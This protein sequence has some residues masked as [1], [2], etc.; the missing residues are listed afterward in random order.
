MVQKSF[1]TQMLL[2]WHIQDNNRHLPWKNEVNPYFIWLSEIMLQQTRAEQVIPYYNKFVKTY[3]TICDLAKAHEDEVFKLWQGLGYY[4]R[5]QNIIYSAR[6]VCNILHGIFP[7]TYKDILLLKG[8][9]AYTA[10]AIASFAFKLPFAVVDGNVY[11]ILSRYFGITEPIT[12]NIVQRQISNLAQELLALK[13]PDQYNQAIMDFGAV[14]CKPKEPQCCN[15]ILQPKCYAF[16]HQL[17][18]ILPIKKNKIKI[19]KRYFNFLIFKYKDQI[20]VEKRKQN[21]IWKNLYQFYLIESTTLLTLKSLSNQGIISTNSKIISSIKPLVTNQQKLTHQKVHSK[22]VVVTLTQ[23][24]KI[25][26]IGE[27]IK[28]SNIEHLAFSKTLLDAISLLS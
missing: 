5:C 9:G 6:Y 2:S 3:P 10:A 25:D 27:W 11:R 16:N 14:V 24:I 12:N 19:V 7:N 18:N 20:W 21:D 8:V 26:D 15:C 23:K 1:F 4:T 17:V 13:S 28:L 22:F